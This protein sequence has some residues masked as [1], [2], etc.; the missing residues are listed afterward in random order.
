MLESQHTLGKAGS[1]LPFSPSTT[2][3]AFS[4]SGRHSTPVPSH[5]MSRTTGRP[6]SRS[7]NRRGSEAGHS[8][9]ADAASEREF[10]AAPKSYA[11]SSTAYVSVDA[12]SS[13][14]HSGPSSLVGNESSFRSSSSS[15]Q[16]SESHGSIPPQLRIISL[17]ED[18]G[19]IIS[20]ESP[21]GSARVSCKHPTSTSGGA[22]SVSV[23][24]E[25][26][27]TSTGTS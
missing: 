16:E 4:R 2:H 11:R 24:S 21:R 14:G 17:D 26:S 10:R 18:S 19:R 12:T 9:A 3:G 1:G 15:S 7:H 25:K 27:A 20:A 8:F 5:T 23:T 13:V 22:D 6:S